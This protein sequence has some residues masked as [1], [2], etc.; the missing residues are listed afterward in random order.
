MGKEVAV[1]DI[2]SGKLVFAT[3]SKNSLGVI[4]V[5]NFSC[6]PYQGYYE[7]EFCNLDGLEDD[8][9]NCIKASGIQKMPKCVYISVPVEFSKIETKSYFVNYGREKL[10]TSSM[11]DEIHKRGDVNNDPEWE[12]ISSAAVRYVLDEVKETIDPYGERATTIRATISYMYVSKQ[13]MQ[14]FDFILSEPG[15][16][17]TKYLCS[18]WVVSTKFIDEES[19]NYGVL[20]LDIGFGSTSLAL[21]KGE[22]IIAQYSAPLGTGSIFNTLSMQLGVEFEEA[23]AI[24]N[25]INLDFV[26]AEGALYT[27]NSQ[28]RIKTYKATDINNS[29]MQR[30]DEIV[31]FVNTSINQESGVVSESTPIYL[32]G[33][34]ISGIKGAL[35]YLEKKLKRRVKGRVPGINGFDKPY[36][37]S[38]IA[39][40][41]VAYEI[42]EN[43]SIWNK[44]F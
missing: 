25:S 16:E 23:L 14:Y 8:V 7:S 12:L 5:S 10:V 30:L 40:L 28:N 3:G 19:R 1:L 32:T 35:L 18:S 44:L 41:D 27:V 15:I 26:F 11:I 43:Q 13:F 24:Q 21:V 29:I 42:N 33:G 37:T 22:G 9:H 4:S 38:F 39:L 36:Y 31:D 2:G 20:S 34:G 6:V 17:H